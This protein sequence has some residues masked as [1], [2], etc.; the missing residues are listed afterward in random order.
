M[1]DE[2]NH[3]Y[4]DHDDKKN[5]RKRGYNKSPEDDDREHRKLKE[6]AKNRKRKI[7]KSTCEAMQPSFNQERAPEDLSDLSEM[8]E[9][10]VQLTGKDRVEEHPPARSNPQPP[11]R[12][13]PQPPAR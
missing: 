2:R 8:E 9:V 6:K 3:N 5:R 10:E 1:G 13:N 12:S 7:R 4:P 11:A